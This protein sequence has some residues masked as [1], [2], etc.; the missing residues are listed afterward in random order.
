MQDWI[1]KLDE[2]LKLSEH[3]LL[4][5]EGKIS[6][7]QAKLKAELEYERYR[8]FLDSQPRLVDSDF[9]K[10]ASELKKLPKPKKP[11]PPKR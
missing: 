6:A 3:E 4:D 1:T 8:V 9:E 5:H 11:K 10:A 7:E 2:F